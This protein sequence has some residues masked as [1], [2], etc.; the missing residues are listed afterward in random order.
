MTQAFDRRSFLSRSL[1]SFGTLSIGSSLTG[2]ASSE[3]F[4]QN[5]S[6]A[7]LGGL[8]PPNELGLR[9][10]K[11]VQARI[12]AQSFQNV[13]L[14]FGEKSAY[15]WHQYPDGG[16]CFA[17]EDGGWIYTSNSEVDARGGGAGALR[18]H[19]NGDLID[20]Y[21]ILAHTDHNCAG[22]PTPW[23]TWLSC[24]EIA[25]GKVYECDIYGQKTA[26]VCPALGYFKHEAVAIDSDWGR[27]Y[28]T[29]DEPDGCLYRYTAMRTE[30]GRFDFTSGFLELASVDADGYVSWIPVP[31]PTPNSSQTPTRLQVPLATHFAGGEGIWYHQGRVLFTTKGDNRVW[32]Y[33]TRSN[34]L[35]VIYDKAT[36]KTDIL[37]GVDNV[38]VSTDGNILVAEDGGD[39]Q[40]V[41]LDASGAVVPLLQ[42][43]GQDDSEITG[44]A[45]SPRGDKL[46]FSSQRGNGNGITY[47]LS[48]RFTRSRS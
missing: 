44:P 32:E 48:G 35:T 24:E 12:V 2:F 1:A 22:G 8:L 29:E 14:A 41:V 16:A 40:I 42:V 19:K 25:Y 20:A 43:V 31:N 28:L 39:M 38:C 4:K 30:N 47:E 34:R 21:P 36:S 10:P 33:D 11:G 37:S 26:K 46:Y 15:A 6:L 27:A 17:T 7:N 23:K 3:P 9:L 45:I 5:Y 18:F 13:P